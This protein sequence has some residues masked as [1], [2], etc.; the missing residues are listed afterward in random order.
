VLLRLREAL[1]EPASVELL[2]RVHAHD[3][4]PRHLP[5]SAAAFL[6]ASHET[7]AWVCEVD[8]QVVGHVALHAAASD[9]VLEVAQ[10]ATRLPAGALAVVARLLVCPDH[11]RQGIGRAL[12]DLATEH[13]RD[14]GQRAVLDVVTDAAGAAA[15]ALYERAG[16]T[17]AG[18][19]T[20]HF[21]DGASLPVA[22][23]LSPE[24]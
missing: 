3:G 17:I 22:V 19:T 20:F 16:W 14:S 2:V 13:A 18:S 1:D 24:L 10:R 11:K 4:Y 12:L 7:S 6:F 21:R 15:A 5:G 8:G 9:P 23:W